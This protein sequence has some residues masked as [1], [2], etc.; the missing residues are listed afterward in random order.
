MNTPLLE[1]EGVAKRF[2][3]VPA[4]I[5]GRLML[6]RGS[7]H[8]L[9]GGNGAGKSTF[10]N[11]LMGILRRDGGSIRVKGEP[12]DFEG[13]DDALRTRISIITQELSPIPGMTVAENIYLGREPR[14]LG[15]VVDYAGIF[16]ITGQ[17]MNRLGFD[18]DPRAP[19]HRL[20][21]AQTQLVEIA[22]AFSH[23]SEIIIMDEP[24]SAIGERETEV[25]F[26]AI[27]SLTAHGAGI[28]YVSH[29]L[30]E[31]FRIADHY[32][33][34]RDGSF[35]ES[36][37]IGDIDR[38][39]LVSTIVGRPLKP[40]RPAE[41]A[42]RAPGAPVLQTI[43]LGRH[44]EFSDISL[45]VHKNEVLGIYGL[46]GAGRS[47]FLNCIYGLS[48]P[49]H[50]EIK[51]RGKK[52]AAGSPSRSI[53]AGLSLVTE[54]RKETGL[55]LTSSIA[56]NIALSAYRR[57]TTLS[58]VRTGEA[59]KLVATMVERMR[60]KTSSTALPV[61]SMSGGNQQKV[62]LARCFSTA[63]MCLMCDEPTRGIDE[64]AKQ[65]VYQLLN[66][67]ALSGG[68]VL[69]VSSEAQEVLDVSDRI[70][71]F[72]AGRLVAVVDADRATQEQLLHLAS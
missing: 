40:L 46:M 48:K 15:V 37:L 49:R 17:L 27:R 66:E 14:R 47:E 43:A 56:M 6:E 4:L 39:H 12:V 36:G 26:D 54:D 63:P 19:M 3:G 42:R 28:V 13:P 34:F 32:T 55:V 10:L 25:L 22:K 57:M 61:S 5:D 1:A 72:K 59:R 2:G 11:I 62:V 18:I 16:A 64:G 45:T 8:A 58:L 70:A 41:K 65:E 50:G 29:R 68:A 7:V 69:L 53:A 31:I 35:V 23:D 51:L 60:M 9:C 38:N 52:F 33:V 44:G 67:F 24:T 71:I 30:S 20:S 21:L